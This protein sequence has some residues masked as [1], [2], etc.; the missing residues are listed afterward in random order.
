LNALTEYLH[1]NT[2]LQ[3]TNLV[4]DDQEAEHVRKLLY[5]EERTLGTLNESILETTNT[6]LAL[7]GTH[8]SVQ[9]RIHSYR[10]CLFFSTPK[11]LPPEIVQ[12]I[13]RHCMAFNYPDETPSSSTAPLLLT[14]I[15][16]AWRKIALSTPDLW[17]N[18]VLEFIGVSAVENVQELAKLWIERCGSLP[19]AIKISSH[20]P[21]GFQMS[22]PL[23]DLLHHKPT[24]ISALD[25]ELPAEY[26]QHF[27]DLPLETQFENLESI[28]VIPMEPESDIPSSWYH[29]TPIFES[30]PKLKK[31]QLELSTNIYELSALRFPW[32]QLTHLDIECADG[33]CPHDAF[34]V[35]KQCKMLQACDIRIESFETFEDIELENSLHFPHLEKLTLKLPNF[36]L[37]DILDIPSLK[38]L[39]IYL[40]T[41]PQQLTHII[42]L[43][44]F[45]RRCNLKL[46]KLALGGTHPIDEVLSLLQLISGPLQ[47]LSLSFMEIIP[48]TT[49]IRHLTIPRDTTRPVFPDL[50]RLW[51]GVCE[52][53]DTISLIVDLLESRGW[54]SDHP[55]IH[56]L[57][58][59][60]ICLTNRHFGNPQWKEP[61]KPFVDRGLDLITMPWQ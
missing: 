29:T 36:V 53:V 30:A 24:S 51:L 48:G 5:Q 26:L 13:F 15:C 2:D 57:R 32:W 46:E 40:A 52:D 49:A 8:A 27:N 34:A 60:S 16:S 22:N 41:S 42:P 3:R 44:N 20:L 21:Q 33:W 17:K 1:Q 45:H 11:R 38:S 14:Q 47:D 54:S 58:A 56:R 43:I 59:L 61:L 12:E 7:S 6:L 25:L 4:L 23:H 50:E 28:S 31:I 37:F 39:S 35:F 18:V 9:A 10:R 55:S 19:Y